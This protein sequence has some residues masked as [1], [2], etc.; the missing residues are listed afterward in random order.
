MLP[1]HRALLLLA[2]GAERSEG[3][4]WRRG[5][6]PPPS[7][8]YAGLYFA[9][10]PPPPPKATVR[11]TVA[12]VMEWIPNARLRAEEERLQHNR[13][14]FTTLWGTMLT[15]LTGEQDM[16]GEYISSRPEA[17]TQLPDGNHELVSERGRYQVYLDNACPWCHSVGIALAL[18]GQRGDVG[19]TQ[20]FSDGN[21]D[22]ETRP[23]GGASGW[24]FMKKDIDPLCGAKNIRE[25]G[26]LTYES[27]THCRDPTAHEPPH[28]THSSR[29]ATTT[30]H[31]HHPPPP[32]PTTT[33]H[34]PPSPNTT[35]THPPPPPTANI[36]PSHVSAIPPPP[37]HP[38]TQVY[39]EC[40]GGRGEYTGQCTLPLMVDLS[41][42]MIISN[43]SG[44]IIRTLNAID[45]GSGLH[46]RPDGDSVVDLCPLDLSSEIESTN[47][48]VYRLITNGVYRA[49]YATTQKAYEAADRDVHLGLD[50]ADAVLKERRFLCGETVTESDVRLLP[51]VTRFDG[52]YAN[53]FKC[54]RKLISRDY[55]HILR[56]MRDMLMLA[57]PNLFNLDDARKAFYKDL[58]P[59]NPS[60]IVPTGPGAAEVGFPGMAQ[61]DAERKAERQRA[62]KIDWHS[63]L[64]YRQLTAEEIAA[65]GEMDEAKRYAKAPWAD[66][67]RAGIAY[68]DATR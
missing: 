13:M 62:M 65:V 43:E 68:K 39:D 36:N 44:D 2:L 17:A 7:P 8:P 28:K 42:K 48:W 35:T 18:R 24:C 38:L 20:V 59:L 52:I 32:P 29:P 14:S 51:T 12:S 27:H 1:L 55:P 37:P 5:P 58:Y 64:S 56:W 33:H 61:D 9:P 16:N 4:F 49:G 53:L 19:V 30:T 67:S 54:G 11:E 41:T 25:V 60:G 26:L 47:E 10:E 45:F 31:H 6:A 23:N 46:K 63:A 21:A 40:S 57:G 66:L 3:V 15:E 34:H 22:K 50:K